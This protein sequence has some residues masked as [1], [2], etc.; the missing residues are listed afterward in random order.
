MPNVMDRRAHE[1]QARPP[2]GRSRPWPPRTAPRHGSGGPDSSCAARP[3]IP[4]YT[5]P[6]APPALSRASCVHSRSTP[7]CSPCSPCFQVRLLYPIYLTVRGGFARLAHGTGFTFDH[8][9][10]IFQDPSAVA[11]LLNSLKIAAG[12]TTLALLIAV[13]LAVLSSAQFRF[14]GKPSSTP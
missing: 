10:L 11:G 8:I 3:V 14:P 13:P 6:H 2:H 7:S 12:T 4:Q 1:A 5:L 9:I